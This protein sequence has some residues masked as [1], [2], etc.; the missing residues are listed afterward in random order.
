MKN[1]KFIFL[2]GI[3]LMST[4]FAVAQNAD[5][6]IN[7]H[8]QAIGGKD[9]ISKIVSLYTEGTIEIMGSQGTMKS[10]ILNGKGMKQDMDIMN[11]TMT[12]CFTDKGG[13]SI[14]PMAGSNTPEDMPAEQYNTGKE[15]IF[16]GAP[17]INY[18]EK[19]YKAELLGNESVG[20]V[21]AFKIKLTSPENAS[22]TYFFDPTT[23]FLIKSI[24]QA[25]MQGQMVN[26]ETTYS[27][28]KE[29]E[30]GYYMPYKMEISMADGQYVLA[31]NLT[32]VEFNKPVEEAVF[33][34]Q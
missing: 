21:S 15:Q 30:T 24:Q 9:K 33:A 34:K 13:W 14:N 28:Y 2:S 5:E 29:T 4:L 10:T 31:L 27:D 1:Y 16:I 7:K 19:G 22:A 20:T 26:N 32:K 3:A 18:T 23:F 25:E 12:T 6:I 17:F 8:I 11:T